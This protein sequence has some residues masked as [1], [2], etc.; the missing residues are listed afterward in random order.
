[1]CSIED[2]ILKPMERAIIKTGLQME[3][4]EGYFGSIRDRSGLAA[5]YSIHVLAG[6]IDSHYRGEVGVVLVNL[7]R[8]EFRINKKDRIAQML[9]QPI[10]RVILKEVEELSNTL[11][12]QGGFGSTGV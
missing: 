5:R 9:I 8:G 1:L 2:Y 11:R 12:G 4:P 3:I 7:D 6:V 10:E